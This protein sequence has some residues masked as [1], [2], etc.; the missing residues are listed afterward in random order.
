MLFWHQ[1]EDWVR[2]D[3]REDQGRE[4]PARSFLRGLKHRVMSSASASSPESPTAS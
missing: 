1:A 2:T 3:F 4:V